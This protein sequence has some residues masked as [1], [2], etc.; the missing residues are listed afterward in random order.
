MCVCACVFVYLYV[1]VCVSVCVTV[2][3]SVC[4]CVCMC[5]C[6]SLC[7]QMCVCMCLCVCL[8]ACVCNCVHVFVC[9]CMWVTVCLCV[10]V[11]LSTCMWVT[12]CLCR[13]SSHSA[14]R[15]GREDEGQH[16]SPTITDVGV[17]PS[18]P[19]RQVPSPVGRERPKD[20]LWAVPGRLNPQPSGPLGWGVDSGV[21]TGDWGWGE[22][23]GGVWSP[24]LVLGHQPGF[25]MRQDWCWGQDTALNAFFP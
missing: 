2:C 15:D 4:V 6:V 10:S 22:H 16:G 5:L 9:V 13:W 25:R 7:V 17:R 3:V 1:S 21:S 23:T 18:K 14:G 12:V 11:S 20:G 8:C 24:L 19:A